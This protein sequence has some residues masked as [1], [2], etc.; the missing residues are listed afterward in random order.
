MPKGRPTKY[1]DEILE[2]AKDYVANHKNYDDPV[3]IV[4]GLAL[5]LG[6]RK[7]TIYDWATQEDKKDFSDTLAAL[8]QKQEHVLVS[9][10]ITNE[11][12]A[13]ITKLMLSNHG[14]TDKKE[15]KQTHE[16]NPKLREEVEKVLDDLD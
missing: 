12:N 10:G 5:L 15:I 13:V 11:H 3:P 6:V 4:A 14:Y 16:I 8:Q 7:S 9:K 2:K 1:N